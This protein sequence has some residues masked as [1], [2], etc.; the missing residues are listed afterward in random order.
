M[1]LTLAI[2]ALIFTTQF[3]VMNCMIFGTTFKAK[4]DVLRT[5][6]FIVSI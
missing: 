1:Q 5:I 3:T 2:F 4:M 6:S